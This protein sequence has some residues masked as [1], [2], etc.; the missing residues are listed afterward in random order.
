MRAAAPICALACAAGPRTI[1]TST[2]ELSAERRAGAAELEPGPARCAVANSGRGSRG[3]CGDVVELVRPQARP[4]DSCSVRRGGRASDG[5]GAPERPAW[6]RPAA[7]ARS[8]DGQLA[9]ARARDERAQVPT[10]TARSTP[11]SASSGARSP[12]SGR[13]SRSTGSSAAARRPWSR[14]GSPRAR[15]GGSH[16]RRLEQVLGERQRAAGVAGQQRVGRDRGGGG[17][18]SLIARIGLRVISLPRRREG[19]TRTRRTGGLP[20]GLRAAIERTLAATARVRRGGPRSG[21]AGEL[22][23]EVGRGAG[24]EAR[25][26]GRER[27]PGDPR[28]RSPGMRFASRASEV[29]GAG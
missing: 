12:R 23:D 2:P 13:R 14:R 10:R 15:G 16:H 17:R 18:W 21:A 7:S 25:R 3:R 22:L 20:E 29:G 26:G 19:E 24:Q 8:D 4:P 28:G 6:C 27:G 1:A 9:R 5:S 11:S